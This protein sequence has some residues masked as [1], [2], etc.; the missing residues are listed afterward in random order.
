MK[1]LAPR[2]RRWLRALRLDLVP[3]AALLL[4]LNAVPAH[5]Q[6]NAHSRFQPGTWMLSASLGGAAFTDFQRGVARA[7]EDPELGDFRRRISAATTATATGSVTYWI[8]S[9]WGLRGSIGYAPSAFSVW[10]DDRAQRVL[11]ARNGGERER[12]SGL[13]VWY[14]DAT[15]IYRLPVRLDRL[16]PYGV[17]GGGMVEYRRSGAAELPPEARERFAGG[18]WRSAAAVIGLG[19]AVPLQRHDMLLNFELTNHL[20]RTPLNE[21][22][23]GEWVQLGGVPVQLD[24]EYDRGDDGIAVANHLRLSVGLTLPLR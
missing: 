11:D 2:D 22:A 14:L 16:V 13:S 23:R 7:S 6:L 9:N 5:A 1:P 18:G 12:Y 15:A 24:R 10:N 21:E 17:V 20:T 4:L 19:T 3:A 8:G